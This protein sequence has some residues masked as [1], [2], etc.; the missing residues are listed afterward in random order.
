MPRGD[1]SAY[2][3]KE[4]RPERRLQTVIADLEIFDLPGLMISTTQDGVIRRNAFVDPQID[5][6]IRRIPRRSVGINIP[7]QIGS[8]KH[9]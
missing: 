8:K 9:M 1:K 7:G 4:K 6:R 2:T 5:I 3:D